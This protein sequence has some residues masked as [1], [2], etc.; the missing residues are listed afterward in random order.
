MSCMCAKE[1][2]QDPRGQA[3][4]MIKAALSFKHLMDP[5]LEEGSPLGY[6][7]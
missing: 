5:S 1:K 3:F 2:I 4:E 7:I 6:R